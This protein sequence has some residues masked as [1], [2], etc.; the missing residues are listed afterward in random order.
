VQLPGVENAVVEPRKLRD[1]LL[2]PSHHE[3]APKAAFFASLGY[4]HESWHVLAR[5][6]RFLAEE[7]D[8]ENAGVTG[9]GRKYVVRGRLRTPS[10]H[11]AEIASV[12]IILLDE[13]FPRFVTAYPE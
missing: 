9:Y 4:T 11:E 10:G 7:A 5:D 2:S 6:L 8:A 1:Y 13:D 3:G 12:W